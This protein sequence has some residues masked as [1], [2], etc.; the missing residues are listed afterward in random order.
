M[1]SEWKLREPFLAKTLKKNFMVHPLSYLSILF[2]DYNGNPQ[3][4]DK[5]TKNWRS[6][7]LR[8]T[9]YRELQMS[10]NTHFALSQERDTTF[11]G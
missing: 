6:P 2:A 5:G 3:L 4:G 7:D 9:V 11:I 1:E 10:R 8:I